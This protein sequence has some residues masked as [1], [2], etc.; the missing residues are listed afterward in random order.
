MSHGCNAPILIMLLFLTTCVVHWVTR[1][2]LES[3]DL[4]QLGVSLTYFR[5]YVRE[6][7]CRCDFH[8]NDLDFYE[9]IYIN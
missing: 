3:L 7:P 8:G 2:R 5:E 6:T 4:C 9:M 1:R